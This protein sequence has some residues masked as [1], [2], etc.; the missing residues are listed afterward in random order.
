MKQFILFI[1]M[2]LFACGLM[3]QD[4]AYP[5]SPPA[6]Q[7]IMKAEYFFDVDPG[8]GNGTNIPVTAATDI[9]N[10]SVAV[11][12]TG[13]SNGFHRLFVRT[14]NNEGS[15]SIA[16]ASDFIVDFNP[17]YPTVTIPLNL[18]R[19]EYFIDTDP[20]TGNGTAIIITPAVDIT[21]LIAGINTTGLSNGIHRLY[22]RSRNNEGSWSITNQ[23]DF[24]VD[25]DPAYPTIPAPQNI[26]RA[27]YF[28]DT[29]PGV[30]NGTSVTITPAV[31]ITNLIAGINT[32]GLSNGI[33]R[34]YIR[35]RNNEGSWSI[36]SNKDFIVDSD[37]AYPST[38][39]TPQNVIQAEYF[40]NT[41]P[42]I[43]NGTPI[44]ITPAVDINNLVTAINTSALTPG[45]TNRLY[46]RTR[47]NEGSWSITNIATFVVDIVSDPV[48][49]AA[50]PA[51]QNVVRAEY[52][53]NADPGIGNGTPITI[54]P[55]VDINNLALSVNTSALSPGTTNRL[56]LRSRN[57]EGSW[58]ITN[59]ATFVVDIVSDPVYPAAPPAPQNISQAE[60]FIDTDSGLGNGTAISITPGLDISNIP[61]SI[62]TTALSV[63]P[64][65]LYVRSRSADGKWSITNFRTFN[66]GTITILPD[67]IVFPSTI[68]NTTATRSLVVRNN[69]S[70]PQTITG[71]TVGAPFTSNFTTTRTVN[72][73]STDTIR[74]SF[75]PTAASAYQDTIVVQTSAGSY[76]T[77]VKG[78]G[79]AV[80]NSWTLEPATGYNYGNVQTGNSSSFNFTI[81]NTGN[82]SITLNEVSTGNPV[83]VPAFTAG[84]II[85]VGGTL[86][87]PV[88]FNPTAVTSYSG[89]LKIKA[90]AGGPDSVTT[91]LNGTGFTPSTPPVLNFVSASPY[92][93][94]RGVNPAAGQLGVFTYK[95]VYR[96]ADNR[97][98]AAGY[99]QI[100][101]DANG[102]QDFTDGGEG[103]YA[104]TKEGTSNDFVTGVVYTYSVNYTSYSN[105]LGY[106]FFANDSLGNAATTVNT[107]YYS[108][109]IVTFQ[110]L[111]LR[112]FANDISFSKTNPLPGE[113]FTVT[114]KIT[115]NSAFNAVNVPVS[116][117][118]DTILIGSTTVPAVNAYSTAAVTRT[119]SFAADGFYPIK[120]WIDS[121][122]TLNE[123]NVLNNYAIRPVIVGSPT[124]PGGITVTGS[125]LVQNCPGLRLI[126]SGSAQYFGTGSP[127]SVAGA[128]VTINTG[129][130]ILKTT[131][132]ANGNFTL[133]VQNPPCGG[134]I[135]YTVSVTDFTFTSN[136]FTGAINVQCPP[137]NACGAPPITGN[138]TIVVTSSTAPCATVAGSNATTN[139]TITY[140]GRNTA[141]F[142]SSW[143]KIWKDTVKIF[144]NGVLIQTYFTNDLPD[145]GSEATF[146]GDVKTYP[147]TVPLNTTGPN[148][149]TAIATY[150]YNE[151]FQ[152]P[153]ST[154]KGIF[155]N[156]TA[157]AGT[158][159]VATPNAP[160]LTINNFSQTGFR[161]FRFDD[162]NIQCGTAGAHVVRVVDITGAPVQL[163]ETTVAAVPGGGAVPIS[164]S[165]PTLAAG[166]YR[167]RIVTDTLAQVA[168][169]NENN[170]SFE[171]TIVVP[172]PDLS[173]DTIIPSNTNVAIGSAIT[174]SATI[175]NTGIAAGAFAVEFRDGSLPIGSNTAVPGIGE[176]STVTARSNVY[177]VLTTDKACPVTITAFADATGTVNESNE[178]NNTRSIQ[179]GTDITPIQV[180]GEFGTSS[181]PVRVRVNT[182]KQFNAYIRNLGSRDITNVTVRFVY[183]GN[184]IGSALVP[185]I[186]AGEQ[187]PAVASFNYTFTTVG[188]AVVT[189]TT[190]TANVACEINETNNSSLYNIVVTDSK[191]DFQVLSQFISPSSLN[192]NTGQNITIAGTVKN[193]GNKVAPPS[194][195]RF[196]VDNIQLGA[197]VPFNTLQI[198]QDTTVAATTTY[199]SLIPGLKVIKIVVDQENLVD[200]EDKTNNEATRIIIVGDA[201][202][203]T[204]NAVQPIGFNPNGFNAG[205]SVTVSYQVKNAGTNTGTAW[206]RFKIFDMSG[207]LLALDS[208]QFTLAPN[209]NTALS[210]KMFFA[211]DSGF[212]VMEI[213]NCTPDESN[214]LNNTDTLYFNTVVRMKANLIVN[215]LDMKAGL[216]QQ[217]PGWIGGKIILDNFN[218]TVNGNIVNYDTAHF[219]ITNG[220]GRLLIVNSS[221][222]NIYPVGTSLF[223]SNFLKL[224]NSG[225]QDNF[226]VRVVP[227]VL[228]NGAAGDTI[229]AGNVNR[230]WFI[231]EQVPGG[232]NAS[233]E[234]FWF[235]GH[236]QSGFNRTF[237]R[238]AHYTT[239]WQVGNAGAAATDT[240][241]GRFSKLQAGYTNFSPFTVTNDVL[242]ALPLRFLSFTAV[243][244]NNNVLLNWNTDN[245]N[246][247]SH[248]D[249]EFSTDARTFTKIGEVKSMNTPGVHQYSFVHVSPA[250]TVLYYRLKQVDLDGKFEYSSVARVNMSKNDKIILTPNPAQNVATLLFGRPSLKTNLQLFSS[251]GQVVLQQQVNEGTRQFNIDISKLPAGIYTIRLSNEQKTEIIKLVKQ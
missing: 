93:G 176:S 192:P 50:P 87:L 65:N 170:N 206:A 166:T 218:L 233:V 11:N 58:S 37:P 173:I 66:V 17:A 179:F 236:E 172:L 105:T 219:I 150:Q 23:K 174:F 197:P 138:A 22:I 34:L 113:T 165:L 122:R 31:D 59:I 234:M 110:Q 130:S 86:N 60:Y 102:D 215:N 191:A 9:N 184:T 83:F 70:T 162:A 244:T 157:T 97:P 202:D 237:S 47:N 36:T 5:A 198:G 78:T 106:R 92:D 214:L 82:A 248:F 210:R 177:N 120:V 212:V 186:K 247:T 114:A 180:A 8:I 20:G 185:V 140:R 129:T 146:P 80:I 217:L 187:F 63:G 228:R 12:T 67:S 48:Y 132:D 158:T 211:V 203:M 108:G 127:T 84:T 85:P 242:T 226:S 40:I 144:N 134:A 71:V 89:V 62:N 19:A 230:T 77:P 24:L 116:F 240:V 94:V 68:I 155:T 227:Y 251:N 57:N 142:W 153:S 41:D 229:R 241:A 32:T 221:N 90:S 154:Y 6:P 204:R 239:S 72:P 188:N 156:E 196:F 160:D 38:P 30:G 61:L 151:F 2:V 182:A 133:V 181:N 123:S 107:A 161:S 205:D 96:S 51:P 75:T 7:N 199:S 147:V 13:L 52:F 124:L 49:P 109:P 44:T 141:N 112:L 53:I 111:D 225:T 69:S 88:A 222:Q 3:A 35:S 243:G 231:E 131:T 200:E 183:N 119:L 45:T 100:G 209:A 168:E 10:L 42:G 232:S 64:H 126:F 145:F 91:V 195:L 103:I 250:G 55:A 18:V 223:S 14:R 213:V 46:L 26:I 33:H 193:I 216:P 16:L 152:I 169:V 163:F 121:A 159:I 73:L 249:V 28:I 194:T 143:D 125:A 220:T 148:N 189:V 4:P 118:R 101:L 175:R 81:R 104:M 15:W 208:T 137:P 43:G 98:P 190:D 245:E 164:V 76:K 39:S 79:V 21:N 201:P 1:S 27:E 238:A 207:S 99:P 29:D 178:S 25:S 139:V 117:Y 235:A 224:N 136:T 171:T 128:E 167:I 54:T 74:I 115:N 149:I 246:N 95:V 135:T 56:Y